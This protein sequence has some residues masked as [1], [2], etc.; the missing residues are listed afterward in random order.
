M[1]QPIDQ[2][3]NPTGHRSMVQEPSGFTR[4]EIEEIRRIGDGLE[5]TDVKLYG[6]YTPDK[7]NARGAH[8]RLSDETRWVFERMAALVARI[9]AATYRYDLTGF[10]ENFYYNVYD[11]SCGQHFN[12]HLDAGYQTPAPRK[13]SAVLQLSEPDEYEGGDFEVMV[14][15]NALA[16]D[17]EFAMISVFPAFRLHRVTPVTSGI[18]RTLVMFAAGPDFR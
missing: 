1:I 13:I 11:G 7:V 9:N 17:K 16:A 15:A 12:W 14:G 3:P 10:H 6:G 8:F 18:R 2:V 5:F 4:E